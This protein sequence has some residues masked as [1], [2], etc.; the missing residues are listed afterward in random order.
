MS[1]EEENGTGGVIVQKDFAEYLQ[2]NFLDYAR[3]VS[4]NRALPDI[5]DGL[6]P[7]GRRIEQTMFGLGLH[8]N[9]PFKKCARIVGQC[10]GLYHPHGDTS[11]YDA[12]VNMAQD[13][14]MRYPLINVHGNVGSIDGDPA[15]AMRYTESRLSMVGELMMKDINKDT[16]D[17]QPNYDESMQEPSVLPTLFPNLLANGTS[18]IAVGISTSFVPHYVKDVYKAL[19]RMIEDALAGKDTSIDDLISI[20]KAPDFPTG[21]VIMNLS[22]VYRG[23]REGEG[24]VVVRSKYEIEPYG[25]GNTKER[26]VITEIPFRVNKS[27]LLDKFADLKRNDIVPDIAEVRD[28][29]NREGMRIVIELRKGANTQWVVNTLLKNTEMQTSIPMRH[30]ALI[31]GHPHEKVTLQDML[32][33]FL[34]H[35]VEVVRR[36]TSFDLNKAKGRQHIIEG[37][38]KANDVIDDIYAANKAAKNKAAAIDAV[39][40]LIGVDDEQATAIIDLHL[41]SLNE[42]SVTKLQEEFEQIN[43]LINHYE[44]ILGEESELLIET[45]K[46]LADIAAQFKNDKRKSEISTE[47]MGDADEREYV[48]EEDIVIMYTHNGMIK[49]V[50]LEEYNAQGRNG[51]GVSLKTKDDDFVEKLITL[52]T[53]DNL[54]FISNV[55]KAYVL[56]AF[57]IPISSKNATAKYASNFLE[58]EG[59]EKI[60]T[61]LPIEHDDTIHSLFFITKNGLGKRLAIDDLPARRNG[62]RVITF[63][64]GDELIGCTLVDDDSTLLIATADGYGFR[65]PVK[66]VRTMGRTAAGV[67]MMRFK[68]PDDCVVSIAEVKDDDKVFVLSQAGFGKRILAQNI[69]L[70]DNKGGKGVIIYKPSKKSGSVKGVLNVKDDENIMVVTTNGMIIR[71]PA[72][73]VGAMGRSASGVRIINLSAGDEVA[74]A[75]TAVQSEEDDS[76]ESED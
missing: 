64:E 10:L 25:S 50:K 15:A 2:P 4:K 46:S 61:V 49:S 72:S 70:R 39:K 48:L 26:I 33:Y 41:W 28:E 76:D 66:Q 13:W 53:K 32:E 60:V 62:A 20:V 75:S 74:T 36:R 51:K 67:I 30:V 45:Q 31:D 19:D 12:L 21:G 37:L 40:E 14:K 35:A 58:M 44:A 63:K 1:N 16:V 3:D 24:R 7:V 56:P 18:G 65:T 23:Y 68:N 34:A 29:S 22:D 55:G 73:T 52:T 43:T 57:R 42:D 54:V 9:T 59:D 71:I 47:S 11:V 27:R 8:P 5:R 69:P 38:V 17:M 6:K